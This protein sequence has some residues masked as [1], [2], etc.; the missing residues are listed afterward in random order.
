MER[1]SRENTSSGDSGMDSSLER[2][3]LIWLSKLVTWENILTISR[4]R[5]KHFLDHSNVE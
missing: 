1:Q 5:K 3:I 2:H 4:E